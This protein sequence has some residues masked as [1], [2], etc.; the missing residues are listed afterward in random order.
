MNEVAYLLDLEMMVRPYFFNAI[1]WRDIK[2]VLNYFK[3]FSRNRIISDEFLKESAER[4]IAHLDVVFSYCKY[5]EISEISCYIVDVLEYYIEY[6][7]KKELYE[8]ASNL[9][10]FKMMINRKIPAMTKI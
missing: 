7:E 3:M 10:R 5:E 6:S 4:L 8:T 9:F 1:V 2:V